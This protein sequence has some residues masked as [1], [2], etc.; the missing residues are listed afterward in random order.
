MRNHLKHVWQCGTWQSLMWQCFMWQHKIHPHKIHP[1]HR[2]PHRAAAAAALCGG[3]PKATP[4]VGCVFTLPH[5]TLPQR[6][7][8]T[9]DTILEKIWGSALKLAWDIKVYYFEWAYDWPTRRPG[10]RVFQITI[11]FSDYYTF[12]RL[13]HI[14]QIT[15][16]FPDYYTFPRY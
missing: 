11:H 5:P 16:H 9:F 10:C 6:I 15:T 4:F 8:N 1:Q 14:F 3:R 2:N 12:F 7:P 13:L